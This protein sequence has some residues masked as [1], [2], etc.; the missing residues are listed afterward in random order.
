MNE[1]SEK[2]EEISG[3]IW[4]NNVNEISGKFRIRFLL[5]FDR[6]IPNRIFI[7]FKFVDHLRNILKTLNYFL[8]KF[9]IISCI[10]IK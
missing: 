9:K 1:T 6:I 3:K 2:I 4:E 10:K 8:V 7:V 5:N